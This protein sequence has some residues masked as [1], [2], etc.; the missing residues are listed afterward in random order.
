MSSTF[1]FLGLDMHSARQY[2]GSQPEPA[3]STGA[4]S[5]PQRKNRCCGLCASV[6]TVKGQESERTAELE[7]IYRLYRLQC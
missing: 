7:E 1:S 6:L 4:Q 2:T 3:S 5:C